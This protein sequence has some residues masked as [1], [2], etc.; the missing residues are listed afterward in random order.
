[1]FHK[2]QLDNVDNLLI[3][4]KGCL[5]LLRNINLTAALLML[6]LGIL[7]CSSQAQNHDD[8]Q[9]VDADGGLS[10]ISGHVR[11]AV[12]KVTS[13]DWQPARQLRNQPGSA[14]VR[15]DSSGNVQCYVYLTDVSQI[16]LDL[17]EDRMSRTEVINRELKIVQGWID[18]R[19]MKRVAELPFV[20]RITPP[21]Y[22]RTL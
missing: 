20:L 6:L 1:L 14:I 13:G 10:K 18:C 5:M 8:V 22:G 11:D 7:S 2:I 21:E 15:I 4:A 3:H 17:L 19:K 9:V 16:K 12:D